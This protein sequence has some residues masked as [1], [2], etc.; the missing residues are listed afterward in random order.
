LRL[1]QEFLKNS[2]AVTADI[3]SVNVPNGTPVIGVHAL[4]RLQMRN[5]L[6]DDPANLVDLTIEL[7]LPLRQHPSGW[8]LERGYHAV[9]DESFVSDVVN[10]V[11]TV[12]NR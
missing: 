2:S 6:L 4:P 12:K 8:F 1:I 3:A 7:L 11:N 5:L 10:R 9:A